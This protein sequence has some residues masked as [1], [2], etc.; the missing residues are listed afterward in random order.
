MNTFKQSILASAVILLLMFIS[1]KK[2]PVDFSSTQQNSAIAS[3]QS[4]NASSVSRFDT[5][6][7]L[8]IGW[9]EYNACNADNID[10]IRGIWHIGSILTINGNT[11]SFQYHTNTS[12]YK[13]LDLNTGIGYTGSYTSNDIETGNYI[14][15]QPLEITSKVKILLTTPGKSNNGMYVADLHLILNANGVITAFVSGFRS[16]CQ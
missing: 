16:E 5:T 1:C 6:I 2:A 7:D 14:I 4:L 3:M 9:H 12:D 8:S 11:Y 13:L 15:G 10:I